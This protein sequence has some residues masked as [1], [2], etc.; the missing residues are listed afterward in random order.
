MSAWWI[1]LYLDECCTV[2]KCTSSS[3]V[4]DANL[5]ITGTAQQYSTVRPIMFVCPLFRELTKTAKLKGMNIDTVPSLIGITR[6]GI[7][8]LEFAKIKGAKIIL[9]AKSP[10]Y[11]AAKLTVLQY[12]NQP[13]ILHLTGQLGVHMGH[14]KQCVPVMTVLIKF[15]FYIH[16]TQY[17]SFRRRYSQPVFWLSTEKN[18]SI[19]TYTT[20]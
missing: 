4:L 13:T 2:I 11:R 19:T 16:P 6:V 7:M 8:Q 18:A 1:Q 9:H 10:T 5:S 3:Y 12:F 15:R 20:T 17:T 14:T